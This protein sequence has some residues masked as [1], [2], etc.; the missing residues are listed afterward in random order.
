[1]PRQAPARSSRPRS[2]KALGV[3]AAPSIPHVSFTELPTDEKR[4]LIM[5]HAEQRTKHPAGNVFGMYLGVAVCAILVLVGWAIALPRTLAANQRSE[6]DAAI[7]AVQE[8][9]AALGASFAGDGERI[10]RAGKATET[11]LESIKQQNAAAKK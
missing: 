8:N 4:T 3:E 7:R 6:P 9:G 10:Q 1:M 5:A 11:L 2:R